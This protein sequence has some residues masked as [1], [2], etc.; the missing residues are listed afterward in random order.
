[1]LTNPITGCGGNCTCSSN[2]EK[3]PKSIPS[4]SPFMWDLVLKDIDERDKMG[5]KKHGVRLRAHNGRDVL[6]DAYQEALDLTVYLRQALYERD[7][8]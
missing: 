4:E 5:E 2:N 7:G 6:K 3:Q 1:L 8:K